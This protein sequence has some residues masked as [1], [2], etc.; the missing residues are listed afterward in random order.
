MTW[1]DFLLGALFLTASGLAF[2]AQRRYRQLQRKYKALQ[3]HYEKAEA[4]LSTL[5]ASKER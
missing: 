4:Q 2:V 5:W 3:Q 1:L